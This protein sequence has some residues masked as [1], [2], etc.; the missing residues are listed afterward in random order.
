MLRQLTWSLAVLVAAHLLAM[1]AAAA[2]LE[3]LT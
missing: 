1:C 3:R 2:L